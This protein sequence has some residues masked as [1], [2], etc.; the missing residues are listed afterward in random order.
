MICSD[1]RVVVKLAQLNNEGVKLDEL[2]D[3]N[4]VC[5]IS[6]GELGFLNWPA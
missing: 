4:Q 1:E 3:V 6:S 2:G 5:K